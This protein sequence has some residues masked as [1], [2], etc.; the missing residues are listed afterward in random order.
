MGG[1]GD[2]E[3]PRIISKK[4]YGVFESEVIVAIVFFY[5]FRHLIGLIDNLINMLL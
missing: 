4:I 3:F 1:C 5:Y 2:L